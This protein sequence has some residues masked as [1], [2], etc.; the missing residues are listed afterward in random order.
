MIKNKEEIIKILSEEINDLIEEN[1]KLIKLNEQLQ[2]EVDSLWMIMDEM[3]QSDIDNHAH[4]L[5]DLK[6]DIITKTLMMSK[7]KVLA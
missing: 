3:T 7:K 1:K 6:T 2:D 5:K 4:L